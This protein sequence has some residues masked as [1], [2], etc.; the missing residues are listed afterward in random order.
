MSEISELLLKYMEF[1]RIY[2]HGWKDR[3]SMKGVFARELREAEIDRATL[4][5][6]AKRPLPTSECFDAMLREL[7]DSRPF[8][9]HRGLC[10][11]YIEFCKVNTKTT[12]ELKKAKNTLEKKIAGKDPMLLTYLKYRISVLE[13]RKKLES[14]L[15]KETPET[16]SNR[17]SEIME[18]LGL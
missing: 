1:W 12:R 9:A 4:A 10:E 15:V 8:L 2:K 11:R 13:E 7:S 6:F 18:S 16:L 17:Y 14:V 5:S 3:T